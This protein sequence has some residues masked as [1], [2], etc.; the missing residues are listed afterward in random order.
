M[1]TNFV[2]VIRLRD[3]SSTQKLRLYV[4]H[5]KRGYNVGASMVDFVRVAGSKAH[6]GAQAKF[7]LEADAIAHFDQLVA[8]AYAQG[9]IVRTDLSSRKTAFASIPAAPTSAPTSAPVETVVEQPAPAGSET[10][11]DIAVG[12]K[13]KK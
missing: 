8:E 7:D 12:K 5:G 6:T 4:V 1:A 10:V 3:F 2:R 11:V 9:W 13:G